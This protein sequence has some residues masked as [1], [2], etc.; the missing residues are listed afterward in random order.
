MTCLFLQVF[1]LVNVPE[2]Q[3]F[4]SERGN[5][6]LEKKPPNYHQHSMFRWDESGVWTFCTWQCAFS[7]QLDELQRAVRSIKCSLAKRSGHWWRP[8][9]GQALNRSQ[10][11]NSTCPENHTEA[12]QSHLCG[13]SYP[14]ILFCDLV[15]WVQLSPATQTRYSNSCTVLMQPLKQ[16]VNPSSSLIS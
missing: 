9:F 14:G 16:E 5:V 13:F 3:S 12:P 11:A 1:I 6:L 15:L 4:L 2:V 10:P 7:E 8:G